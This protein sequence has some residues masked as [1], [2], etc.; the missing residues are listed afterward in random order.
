MMLKLLKNLKRKSI[1]DLQKEVAGARKGVI[2][3]A[4][5]IGTLQET[6][7][8]MLSRRIEETKR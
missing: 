6:V 3:N 1:E 7:D 2:E 4:K 8:E 5:K